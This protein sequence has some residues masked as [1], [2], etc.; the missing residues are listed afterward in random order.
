MKLV[1]FIIITIYII[2]M[3]INRGNVPEE[4]PYKNVGCPEGFEKV[5]SGLCS[6]NY[7][8]S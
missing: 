3:P 5:E 4:F 1:Y 8:C 6:S 2:I 7:K